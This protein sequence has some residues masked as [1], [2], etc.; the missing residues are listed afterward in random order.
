MYLL[1]PTREISTPVIDLTNSGTLLTIANTSPVNLAAPTSPEPLDTMVI[2]LACDNGAATSAATCEFVKEN[3]NDNY[4]T[5]QYRKV[6]NINLKSIRTLGSVSS[7]MSTMAASRYSLH[8][9]AFL[10]ICSASAFALA[11]IAK[12][13]A[14]PRIRIY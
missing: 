3:K 14:S 4:E 12:A 8:A 10:A 7:N 2:F 11:E 5:P 9:S 1:L 6:C 13:S